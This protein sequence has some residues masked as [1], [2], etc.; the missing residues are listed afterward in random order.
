MD[1][2]ISVHFL[3]TWCGSNR[4]LVIVY[5]ELRILGVLQVLA[6]LEDWRPCCVDSNSATSCRDILCG[7][8]VVL[9]VE[10]D[11]EDGMVTSMIIPASWANSFKF[12]VSGVEVK[13]IYTLD[14]RH[15]RKV[16]TGKH[17]CVAGLISQQLLHLT[18]KL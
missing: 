17:Y 10:I 2:Y 5:M 11:T 13:T 8:W 14:G 18:H 1:A 12:P 15:C 16:H 4:I 6:Y 7:L 9:I 3:Q